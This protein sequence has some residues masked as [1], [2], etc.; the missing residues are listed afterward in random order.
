V[1]H[2]SFAAQDRDADWD[3]GGSRNE[4]GV[5]TVEPAAHDDTL[6]LVCR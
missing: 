2:V 4:F 3:A 6:V 5:E 1:A